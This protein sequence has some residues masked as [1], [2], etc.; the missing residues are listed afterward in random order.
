[1]KRTLLYLVLLVNLTGFAQL[2]GDYTIGGTSPDYATINDAVTALTNDG[3]SGP[4]TFNIRT[5]VYNEQVEIGAIS[6]AGSTSRITFQ[7]ETNSNNDVTIT[8]APTG[9]SDNYTFKLDAA[10]YITF[11][12]L[13]LETTGTSGYNHVVEMTNGSLS[14]QF[15][16]NKILGLSGDGASNSS[17]IP[18]DATS[19]TEDVSLTI[20]YNTFIGADFKFIQVGNA[21]SFT[22]R[23]NTL[24]EGLTSGDRSAA[25]WN[26]SGSVDIT[27]NK[28]SSM[29]QVYSIT[30][31]TSNN[32]KISENIFHGLL[33]TEIYAPD[34]HH[35]QV[36]NNIFL[37]QLLVFTGDY[38]DIF[39]NTFYST[40]TSQASVWIQS[41][42]TNINI[43]NNNFIKAGGFQIITI[44]DIASI[45]SMDYNN[46]Y[47]NGS[48]L[49]QTTESYISLLA[50]QNASSFDMNSFS[51]NPN[52]KDVDNND[53]HLCQINTVLHGEGGLV[54][55]DFDNTTRSASMPTIGAYEN[56]SGFIVDGPNLGD[57]Q[58]ICANSSTD[59]TAGT[60]T[61]YLW[62]TGEDTET[63]TV[64]P[65]S[66]LTYSITVTDV[67]GCE[68]SDAIDVM[69]N[70]LPTVDLGDNQTVCDGETFT[71]D[72]GTFETYL[73]NDGSEQQTLD[74][75]TTGD[76]SVEVTDANGCANSD[77]VHIDFQDC[78]NIETANTINTV[79]IYPNPAKQ[80]IVVENADAK[81]IE[82]LD[83]TGKTIKEIS[84]QEAKQVIDIS[85]LKPG[86]Y[87]IK[88]SNRVLKFIK[89]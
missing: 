73:W 17:K 13:T 81:K 80:F 87:F 89:E 5:G 48:S 33:W 12:F 16:F 15:I 21:G 1:M 77:A 71:L 43:K 84:N 82:F 59:L 22:F 64:S 3:I 57:D 39:H 78:T 45:N 38:Y 25:F 46:Y 61:S 23:G 8:Y 63:V 54:T 52:F 20:Y 24:M 41:N 32:F 14:I 10:E 7:S 60:F 42:T 26:L 34:Y 19:S 4:V 66:S 37:N 85:G 28:F 62:S 50:W 74:V 56:T 70:P 29:V 69:I 18:F 35:A 86:V 72:A 49:I 40:N 30:D 51:V 11:Q 36:E 76:Y 31:S 44:D 75:T 55:K 9:S 58:S 68:F 27:K 65:S 2:N 47:N 88:S 79:S 67:E 6:G 53:F 83:I